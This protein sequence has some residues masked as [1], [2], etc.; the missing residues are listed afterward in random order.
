MMRLRR[1]Q[2][3]DGRGVPIRR[4][5]AVHDLDRRSP[6]NMHANLHK[7][8]SP[9]ILPQGAFIMKRVM[10]RKK[11]IHPVM[12]AVLLLALAACA[13]QAELVKTQS[14]MSGL[15]DDAKQNKARIEELQKRLTVLDTNIKGSVDVQKVMADYG[16]KTDQLTT[17]IQLLQGK[18]EEN[19]FRIAD[20][21]QKLDDKSFKITELSS[22]VEELEAKVKALAAGQVPATG[23]TGTAASRDK[24][25]APKEVEPSEAYR[26]AMNDYN[27]GN[28]DLALAGFKN[29]LAQFPD[30]SLASSAQYW[31]GQCY[32][33]KKDYAVAIDSWV[34]F[35]KAYPKSDKVPGAE[36]KIGYSYLSENNHA[37]AKVWLNRVIKE[38]PDSD[39]AEH[40]KAKLHGIG[41]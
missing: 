18:L 33:A 16:A 39:E 26:L 17:D 23:P 8:I 4:G 21:A 36:L 25:S 10:M 15:R 7:R 40:A 41:K 13:P 22:R 31:V 1:R 20:L 32:Y 9:F 37:K 24:K 12:V 2:D 5:T 11:K 34:Q 6:A 30:T 14:E 38:Y 3:G 29:Y 27:S 19:N 35:I 28:F